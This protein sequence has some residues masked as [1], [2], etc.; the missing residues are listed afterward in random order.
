M[1]IAF[2]Y[3][4]LLLTAIDIDTYRLPNVLVG[5]LAGVKSNTNKPFAMSDT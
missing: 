2:F 4:L 3:V 1:G 5:V